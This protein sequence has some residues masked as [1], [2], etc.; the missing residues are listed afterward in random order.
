MVSKL[1]TLLFFPYDRDRK[2]LIWI[3]PLMVL[4]GIGIG[5]LIGYN[6]GFEKGYQTFGNQL[7]LG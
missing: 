4:I 5:Y 3:I 1:A 7:L 2:H 6:I